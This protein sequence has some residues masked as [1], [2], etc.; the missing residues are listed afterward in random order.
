[1]EEALFLRRADGTI[2]RV[3]LSEQVSEQSGVNRSRIRQLCG[4]GAAGVFPGAVLMG[5]TWLIPDD[6]LSAWL[7]KP[8]DERGRR[9]VRK[10]GR[11]KKGEQG[12]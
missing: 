10:L 1:M 6:E 7:V 11:P 12:E 3:W 8:K 2:I 4:E 5:H 9:I